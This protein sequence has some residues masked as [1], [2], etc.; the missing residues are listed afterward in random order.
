MVGK[1]ACGTGL[2]GATPNYPIRVP[3]KKSIVHVLN[4]VM[5]RTRK[6]ESHLATISQPDA[7]PVKLRGYRG[8]QVFIWKYL[9]KKRVWGCRHFHL[10][11][12]SSSCAAALQPHFI[13]RLL[14]NVWRLWANTFACLFW[15]GTTSSA[16]DTSWIWVCTLS[17]SLTKTCLKSRRDRPFPKKP[18]SAACRDVMQNFQNPGVCLSRL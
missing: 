15:L 1:N 13:K 4:R 17:F 9:Y 5:S 8:S 6:R 3:Q 7:S 10:S 16:A 14:R 2:R 11:S 18:F 12:R